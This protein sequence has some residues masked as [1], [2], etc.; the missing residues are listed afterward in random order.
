MGGGGSTPLVDMAKVYVKPDAY[1]G[2]GAYARLPIKK[3]ELVEKGIVRVH[4]GLD[5][6]KCPFVFT[7][8]EEEPRKWA[9]GSG[10]SVFYNM[11]EDP[12]THM[13]RD[14]AANTFEILATRDIAQDEELTHVYI[15]ATWRECFADLKPMAEKYLENQ[16][17]EKEETTPAPA[18]EDCCT[19]PEV[20]LSKD[21]PGIVD[22]S[23]VEVKPDAYGGAGVYAKTALKKDELIEKGIIRVLPLDGNENPFV[24]TWSE[25]EPR[26]WG[27]G[28]GA[29]VFYNMSETPN[30]HMSRNF[31]AETFEIHATRDIAEGEELTHVYISATWRKCFADLKPLAERYLE[32]EKK[33]KEDAEEAEKKA[34]EEAEEAPTF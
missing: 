28:S 6:N 10:A 13:T 19:T 34:K 24:F 26:K 12:N 14:F 16:K 9:S 23:K 32:A 30:T 21:V 20:D 27:S 18:A 15:S 29:S 1:G 7:W 4:E 11:S 8:S 5:G 2:A 31:S 3:G 25:G 33:A 17:K 22:M